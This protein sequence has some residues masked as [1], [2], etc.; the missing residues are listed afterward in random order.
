MGSKVIIIN[1]DYTI[2]ENVYP[3]INKSRLF[4]FETF[5]KFQQDNYRLIHWRY[6]HGDALQK[7]VTFYQKSQYRLLCNQS[8]L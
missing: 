2:A 4:I 7:A 8:R 1:F 6:H 3:T 5:K